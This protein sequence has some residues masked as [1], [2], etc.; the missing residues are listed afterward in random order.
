MQRSHAGHT[1]LSAAPYARF[2]RSYVTLRDGD[3]AIRELDGTDFK[4]FGI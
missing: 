2:A 3:K 1:S 4:V